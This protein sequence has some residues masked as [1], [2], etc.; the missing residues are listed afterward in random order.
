MKYCLGT[1]VAHSNHEIFISQRKYVLA[2]LKETGKIRGKPVE[3]HIESNHRLGEAHKMDKGTCQRLV[4]KLICLSHTRPN[5]AYAIR[6]VR[7]FMNN[8]KDAHFQV[9]I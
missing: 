6:V 8:S 9:F 1:E 7:K 2:L 3:S 4:G 5:I